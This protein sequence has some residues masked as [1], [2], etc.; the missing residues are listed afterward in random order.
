M[1]KKILL[2]DDHVLV[3]Q[4]LNDFIEAHLPDA[5]VTSTEYFKVFLSFLEDGGHFDLAIVDYHMPGIEGI[6]SIKNLV[7]KNE[8]TPIA[9]LSGLASPTE[10]LEF[11]KIGVAGFIP[12]TH[13]G[14]EFIYAIELMLSG[15]VYI[16]SSIIQFEDDL[17]ESLPSFPIQLTKREESVLEKLYLGCS[18]KEIAKLLSIEE[19]TVKVYV[20]R[21][22]K[23]F[24][25]KNRT[26]VVV[27]ALTLGNLKN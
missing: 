1:L 15:E 19:I 18:N 17:P 8:S 9:V 23:K 25:A 6:K 2:C 7:A 3:L 10:V 20:S 24:D 4:T 13:S 22:C 12:K 27:R 21:L 14:K 5:E 11:V 26:T 16:P